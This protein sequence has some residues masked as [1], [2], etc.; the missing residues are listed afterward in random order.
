MSAAVWCWQEVCCEARNW[1]WKADVNIKCQNWSLVSS[2]RVS[3]WQCVFVCVQECKAA[4]TDKTPHA[5]ISSCLIPSFCIP[6]L[7]VCVCVC[8]CVDMHHVYSLPWGSAHLFYK[9]HLLWSSRN[10]K[11]IQVVLS[12]LSHLSGLI[13]VSFSQWKNTKWWKKNW[14]CMIEG[15]IE[16][17][18]G[19]RMLKT[20]V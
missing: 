12:N 6:S 15:M 10:G 4:Q 8:R 11:Q 2:K 9:G 16:V 3:A 20:V 1:L 13:N 17:G 5:S 7:P 18:N 14:V 19:S